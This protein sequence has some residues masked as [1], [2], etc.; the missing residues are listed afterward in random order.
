MK[1]VSSQIFNV[2][3]LLVI[4]IL[5]C[6]Q[7]WMTEIQED[8]DSIDTVFSDPEQSI[9]KEGD[10]THFEGLSYY[11]ISEL[12]RVKAK[13]Q[14]VSDAAFFGMKTTT[15]RLPQ[16]RI[17][18]RIIFSIEGKEHSLN[19]YQNKD[20]MTNPTYADHLFVPFTD[21]S[22]YEGTYPG[23]RYIDL[24]IGDIQNDELTIDFNRCY[25][26]YCAYNDRYSCPIPPSENHIERRIE[27]GVKY[28]K[29]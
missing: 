9:L 18:G 1:K 25:N 14:P 26:P 7:D 4:P 10:L 15:D 21:D 27:A 22:N 16:Y 6:S 23:G 3:V 12:Y 28:E 17:Y 24:E 11:P 5:G 29:H 20:L 13:F 19:V 8:R 2:L